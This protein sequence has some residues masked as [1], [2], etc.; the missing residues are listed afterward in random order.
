M[1]RYATE[2]D[3]EAIWPMLMDLH[4]RQAYFHLHPEKLVRSLMSAIGDK[5]VLVAEKDGEIVG[6]FAW[7]KSS[8]YFS[9]DEFLADLWMYV[10]PGASCPTAALRMKREMKRAARESGLPLMP[11]VVGPE[12]RANKMFAN[13]PDFEKAGELY[14]MRK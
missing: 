1:I 7:T 12:Q 8:T 11:G 10:K 13:D 9:N 5:S 14:F 2:H 3:A 6:T 4:S